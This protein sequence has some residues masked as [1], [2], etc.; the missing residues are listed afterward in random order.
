M[1]KIID[2]IKKAMANAFWGEIII[3]FQ[4]GK[5]VRIQVNEST[6]L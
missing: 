1:G 2:R 6:K 5:P 4:N 3:S